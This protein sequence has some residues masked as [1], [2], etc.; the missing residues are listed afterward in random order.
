MTQSAKQYSKGHVKITVTHHRIVCNIKFPTVDKVH[1]SMTWEVMWL[2][3]HHQSRIPD[4]VCPPER[5]DF[6]YS[7]LIGIAAGCE[8]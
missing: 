1:S 3:A 7:R 2:H 6:R 5:H 8:P 4:I